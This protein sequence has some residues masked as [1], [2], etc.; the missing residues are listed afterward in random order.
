MIAQF[1]YNSS[2]KMDV[3]GSV[4]E[5]LYV[6]NQIYTIIEEEEYI[7][8]VWIVDNIYCKEPVVFYILMDKYINNFLPARWII[9][10]VIP[11]VKKII[12]IP[13]TNIKN[14]NT[15][16]IHDEQSLHEK[17]VN[18]IKKRFPYCLFTVT[19]GENQNTLAKRI[20]SKRMGYIKGN[21]DLI[22]NNC[23]KS[24]NGFAIEFKSPTGI[25]KITKE[26]SEIIKKYSSN[27]FKVLI[28]ND[29][30]EIIEN[31]IMYFFHIN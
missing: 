21:V 12:F 3:Y 30:D 9:D 7:E 22:I 10:I 11:S 15:F 23:N 29:Y 13:L 4:E 24:Y 2:K 14:N 20:K 18:F 19:L 1:T 25:G 17:V 6:I 27:N 28:S 16:N 26:Q 8:D 31:I 5:P